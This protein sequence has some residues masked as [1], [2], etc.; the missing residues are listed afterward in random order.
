MDRGIFLWHVY[1]PSEVH[2]V[3]QVR[4]GQGDKTEP[5]FVAC[6]S[7]PSEVH[8]VTQVRCGQG[9]K[10]E[11]IFVACISPP[12]EVHSVTQVRCGQ[13]DKTEPILRQN[14]FLFKTGL[15]P[16]ILKLAHHKIHTKYKYIHLHASLRVN[17][18][19]L[20]QNE[21]QSVCAE[22]TN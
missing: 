12:S 10:T 4:C 18:H 21:D 1:P 6:I 5:I 3:T 2:S 17:C 9:D 11:P 15:N 13:G 19:S 14:Q 8:S 22:S 16:L 20:K 7:P